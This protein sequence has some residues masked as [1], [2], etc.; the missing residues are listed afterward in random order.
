[1]CPRHAAK[2]SRPSCSPAPNENWDFGISATYA[3][4]KLQSSVLDNAGNPIAGMVS[5]ARMPTAPKLQAVASIGFTLPTAFA[6]KWDFYSNVVGQYVGDSYT[7][8]GD[9]VAGFGTVDGGAFFHFGNPTVNGFT[10]DP[11]LPSYQIV[12]LRAGIRAAGWDVGAYVNNVTDEI[13]YL[14]V[15]RERGRRARVGFLTNQPRTF[16]VSIQRKF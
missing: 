9:E 3:D 8:I 11:K 16:G 7:Q 1:M 15:D 4:A 13:A 5:G 2:A 10:F 14:S 6:N 12:N